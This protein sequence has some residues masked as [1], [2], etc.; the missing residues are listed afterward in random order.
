MGGIFGTTG[1]SLS[2]G[3]QYG[4]GREE[5]TII[6]FRCGECCIKYQVRLS[7]IEAWRVVDYLGLA[8]DEWLDVYVDKDWRSTES[9]VLRQRDGA[10]V[11]LKPAEASK[12]TSCLIH[13][14]KP[15]AC[16]EWIPSLFRRECREGLSR[17]W[18]LTV[19]SLGQLEGAEEKLRDF[20]SFLKSPTFVDNVRADRA[21]CAV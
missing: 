19:S 9:F 5:P 10:C 4:S 6:C 13:H 15:S 3:I 20:Y 21:V 1:F 17:Y 16:R 12:K 18:G 2:E 11:F 14:V 8:F 7:L